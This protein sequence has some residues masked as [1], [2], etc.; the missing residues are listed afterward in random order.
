MLRGATGWLRGD[1]KN[2]DS[3]L[4]FQV[5]LA[6]A[7]VII[8]G[9]AL[10]ILQPAWILLLN[11]MAAST[12]IFGILLWIADRRPAQNKTLDDLNL[13]D[14][15]IIGCAQT[16]ALIPGTS[17]SGITMTAARFLGYNRTQSA[18]FSLLLAIVAITGAGV[19]GTLELIQNGDATLSFE[20]LIAASIAFIAGLISITLLMKWLEKCSFVP[21]AIYRIIL[22]LILLAIINYSRFS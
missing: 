13:K 15:L 2:S 17:R 6:S 11:V 4:G 10:H 7:P 9:L 19:L 14:A 16:L 22:G 21:F 5:L 1:F 8:A 12:L 18:R 20:A 3:R